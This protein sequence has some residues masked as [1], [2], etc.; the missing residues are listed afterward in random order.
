MK[1]IVEKERKEKRRRK[2]PLPQT[3]Y[4]PPSARISCA[5]EK[6]PEDA[7][8]DAQLIFWVLEKGEEGQ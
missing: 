5:S 2:G 6:H 4:D 7:G 3:Q 1:K 8:Y